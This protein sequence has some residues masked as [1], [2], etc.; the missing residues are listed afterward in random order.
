LD[1]PRAATT[2]RHAAEESGVSRV[3]V[4]LSCAALLAG[5]SFAPKY[6]RP[7]TD[8][9]TA[10]RV[11]DAEGA[12]LA[13]LAWW[14]VFQDEALQVLVRTALAENR[15]LAIAT[16]RIEQARAQAGIVDAALYPQISAT[17]SAAR[18]KSS[19][20]TYPQLREPFTNN[21]FA[22]SAGAAFELDLWGRLRNASAAA[23]A[24]LLA[25]EDAQQTVY[26]SLVSEVAQTYFQL[27]ASDQDL[28]VAV[29]TRD[30]RAESLR[31]VQ[32][33]YDKG[34]ASEL[35]L[36]QAQ[37]QYEGAVAAIPLIEQQI[38]QTENALSILLGRNP[39]PI[40]RGIALAQQPLPPEVPAGL[41]SALLEQR[42]D[43]QA[44]EQR[45]VQANAQIGEA[46]ALYF[47]RI[48]LTGDYGYA[49]KS[50]SDLFSGP[51]RVWQGAAGFAVPI[52]DA[53]RIDA[54]VDLTQA[55]QR[56]AI[57]IYQQSVQQAFREVDDALVAYRKT[58]TSRDAQVRLVAAAQRALAAA[59]KR[60]LHG[61]SSYLEVLDAQRALFDAE[62]A[63]TRTQL[64]ELV[65]VVQLYRALGGGWTPREP[66]AVPM[67]AAN[68]GSAPSLP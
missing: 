13:E 30:T 2:I 59:E 5:C 9:P 68:D 50:L 31:I 4:V 51:A 58:R 3:A 63:L 46:R 33:R 16:V 25:T 24:N 22:L 47:P 19:A 45:I 52:F 6:E 44:A 60:Y 32:S 26:I 65:A 12:S 29:R 57:L 21:D 28:E 62:L 11:P 67:T 27:R 10:W 38:A 66:T 43:L 61:V 54:T 36:A 41:P 1:R 34:I 49:S 40:V 23:R 42:P 39:G 14:Q 55:R 20:V 8:P 15:N 53:G 48:A 35:D 37:R 7:Q 64:A 56:E 18:Q 17:G